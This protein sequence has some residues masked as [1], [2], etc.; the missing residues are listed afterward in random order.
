MNRL[1]R[2]ILSTT[3]TQQVDEETELRRKVLKQKKAPRETGNWERAGSEEHQH[4]EQAEK[5]ISQ[6]PARRTPAEAGNVQPWVSISLQLHPPLDPGPQ[7]P[8][9]TS[10]IKSLPWLSGFAITND[11]S[12]LNSSPKVTL[13]ASLRRYSQRRKGP[14]P[15]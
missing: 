11:E 14:F 2:T 13:S 7:H 3:H 15:L 4:R 10:T 6:T 5:G 12:S 9:V 8:S 1:R